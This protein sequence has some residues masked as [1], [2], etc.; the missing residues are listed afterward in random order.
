LNR[1]TAAHL[2]LNCPY[3]DVYR[4]AKFYLSAIIILL[5]GMIEV[6]LLLG[7][8]EGKPE[9]NLAAARKLIAERCGE[10]IVASSLYETE[11]WGIKEQNN[12]L[13]QAI[14][15]KTTLSPTKLLSALKNIE[16]EIGRVETI[17]WGPRV[18]DIDILFYGVQVINLPELKIPHPYIQDR[19]FTLAPVSQIA[20]NFVHPVI[21]KTIEELLMVCKDN[22]EVRIKSL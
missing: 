14:L 12:F 10:I 8:N 9:K 19:R 1:E 6:Y 16:K 20:P 18:I 7:S 4:F 11:A 3:F 15:L 22:S 5:K 2:N 21:G 13:N 17:H